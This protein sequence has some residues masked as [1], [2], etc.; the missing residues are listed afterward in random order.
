MKARGD[1]LL[2]LAAAIWGF[3]FVAQR[4]G[5]AHV[6]PFVFNAVRFTLG[7]VVLL[8]FVGRIRAHE[9]VP[10]GPQ[11]ELRCGW[12]LRLRRSPVGGGFLAGLFLFG[13]I[14]LQQMGIVYTTAGKAGFITGLYVVI[15]PLLALLWGQ[16]ASVGQW[17]GTALATTGLYL[18]CVTGHLE[19]GR[20]DLL[21]LG[22]ACFWAVHVHL[23]AWLT[24][25]QRPVQL[26]CI[27]FA[28]CAVLSL[29]V[30]LL[31]EKVSLPGMRAAAVPILYAGVLSVGVA[32]TL[33]VVAQRDAHPAHAA[34]LLSMEA[35][36]A[37]VGGMI[38]LDESLTARAVLGCLL[39]LAGMFASQLSPR[40]TLS[41]R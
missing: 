11:S 39:M 38:F 8:P 16:R 6:G 31:T 4:V 40:R 36:F 14:S 15:V 24:R 10:S 33:Q 35:V 29:L 37:V 12:S 22:G 19:V 28:V 21:V 17:I 2:L 20:G 7:V 1:A 13:G 30:A 9:A 41:P 34:I 27:Q 5:M 23:I 18:L 26:A 3:A 32:Y 25:D